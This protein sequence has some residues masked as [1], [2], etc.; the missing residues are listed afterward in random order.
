MPTRFHPFNVNRE[1]G[2]RA[3]AVSANVIED[4]KSKRL[5][6]GAAN[7]PVNRELA[8]LRRGF[9]LGERFGKV[10]RVPHFDMLAEFKP[11]SGFLDEAQYRALVEACEAAKQAPWLRAFVE[12]AGQLSNRRGEL[13]A[14]R[15]RDVDFLGDSITLE[16]TKKR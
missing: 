6:A 14:L 4:Y 3:A 15:V 13:L 8:I 7:G 12:V 5:A 2:M 10:S 11:R 1:G 9:R 16:E